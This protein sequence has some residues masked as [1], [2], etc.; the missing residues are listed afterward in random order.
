L[1]DPS[2]GHGKRGTYVLGC[3]CT[4]CSEAN[5]AYGRAVYQAHKAGRFDP[6]IDA[7]PARE[8]IRKLSRAGVGYKLLADSARL[9]YT[10]VFKIKSGD[11]ERARESTVKRILAVSIDC[12]SDFALVSA[13]S[14]WI[15]INKL[16]EEGFTREFL[17][18]ELGLK[19]G[20]LHIRRY[21]I[22]L[23]TRARIERLFERLTS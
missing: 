6:I 7:A 2:A 1:G 4:A 23:K 11:S 9:A 17:A 18:R 19:G 16:I 10:V 12:R 14:T 15:L 13:R 3:R 22:R 5:K 21:R 8:H 20:V